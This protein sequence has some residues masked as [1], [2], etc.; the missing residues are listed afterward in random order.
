[1]LTRYALTALLI[2]ALPFGGS[3]VAQSLAVNSKTDPSISVCGTDLSFSGLDPATLHGTWIYIWTLFRDGFVEQVQQ[4]SISCFQFPCQFP[5]FYYHTTS[6]LPG[7]YQLRLQVKWGLIIGKTLHSNKVAVA[8]SPAA[9]PT[10]KLKI[11]GK[12]GNS[13]TICPHDPIVVDGSSSLCTS[14]YF[15]SVQLSDV[16]WNRFGGEATRWLSSSDYKTYGPISSFNA[17]AFAE[18]QFFRFVGGQY[19]RV[20]LAVVSPWNETTTLVRIAE[21]SVSAKLLNVHS[22]RSQ[23]SSATGLMADIQQVCVSKTT[24]ILDGASSSCEDRYFI[25]AMELDGNSLKEV[26]SSSFGTWITPLTQAP[27]NIN[28][29]AV[30]ASGGRYFEFGKVYRIKLAVGLPWKETVVLVE[31]ILC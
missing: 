24:L 17:K 14:A 25:E 16:N 19:Y 7:V 21:P 8:I 13:L 9:P 11:N 10:A 31:Y 4:Q 20:K 26:P 12:E 1:M 5:T 15:L 27:A 3:A 18:R 30:Y 23:F 28:L 22:S 29:N 2:L 6:G